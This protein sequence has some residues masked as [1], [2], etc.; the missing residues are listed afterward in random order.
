MGV[1]TTAT[2]GRD[3]LVESHPRVPMRSCPSGA[4][5]AGFSAD[6]RPSSEGL[7][8]RATRRCSEPSDQSRAALLTSLFVPTAR[9]TVVP[10]R[11][12]RRDRTGLV[13]SPAAVLS[14]AT[15]PPS[16]GRRPFR[17]TFAPVVP[18]S[19]RTTC[20]IG[21]NFGG[22]GRTRWYQENS[23]DLPIG[24]MPRS[25][26]WA[27]SNSQ[28]EN[29]GSIPV[30]RSARSSRSTALFGGLTVGP[31]RP[32]WCIAVPLKGPAADFRSQRRTLS[33]AAAGS[34]PRKGAW[35][36]VPF[37]HHPPRGADVSA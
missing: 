23:P 17:A 4:Y 24:Q 31:R 12:M 32:V 18:C 33:L 1:L 27:G 19:W 9:L 36:A 22:T 11:E 15:P 21:K 13:G 8:A 29:A 35:A 20:H 5:T 3:F 28:A 6:F 34:T 14:L 30:T 37:R 26:N 10:H 2:N 16:R 25:A 7:A